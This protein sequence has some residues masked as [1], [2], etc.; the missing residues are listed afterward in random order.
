MSISVS[1]DTIT[2]S[3]N[4]I[5]KSSTGT[6]KVVR[7]NSNQY[8]KGD[9]V[10]GLASAGTEGSVIGSYKLGRANVSIKTNRYSKY[11][12]D[13]L[14]SKYYLV[15]DGKIVAGPY[16]ATSI[17]APRASITVKI[18]SKKGIAN[19][20]TARINEVKDLGAQ[21][22][23]LNIVANWILRP[24]EDEKGNAISYEGRSDVI[25]F[26]SNGTTYYFDANQVGIYDRLISQYTK[27]GIDV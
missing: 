4:R 17:S 27:A 14:Y 19:E 15:K 1:D 16:Y 22:A 25:P 20:D 10:H 12:R 13:Y 18:T 24:N 7:M 26:E 11:G 6:A 3:M 2:I 21:H 5:G 8:R 23:A 9:K